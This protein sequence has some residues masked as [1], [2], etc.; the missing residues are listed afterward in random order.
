MHRLTHTV[1]GAAAL[2]SASIAN[3]AI[4]VGGSGTTS[5]ST[6]ST[7]LVGN[8]DNS[9]IPQTFTFD[10][11]I[12]DNGANSPY[13]SSFDFSNDLAGFYNFSVTTAVLGA[14]ITLEQLVNQNTFLTVASNSQLSGSTL[15]L[16]TPT[17]LP[18]TTYRFTYTSVLSS[19]GKV[20]GNAAFYPVP[21]PASWALMIVGFAGIG[22]AIRRRRRPS[23]SQ[24][25]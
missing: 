14:S 4:V 20:S 13:T 19:N 15:G 24:L 7:I 11:I 23:F 8:L 10:T 21:E 9:A 12:N 17:L 6:G 16:L 22:F 5:S 25:A 2:A 1:L 3:A 18:N